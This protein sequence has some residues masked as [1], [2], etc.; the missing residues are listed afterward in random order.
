[1]NLTSPTIIKE[2]LKKYETRASK[3]LGQNFLIDENVLRKI[4]EAGDIKKTDTILEVGPGIGV[5]TKELASRAKKII[6]VEKSSA[7]QTILKETIK[8]FKN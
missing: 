8:D 7:M 6:A 5:L 4:V 2:L 3:G 1:M